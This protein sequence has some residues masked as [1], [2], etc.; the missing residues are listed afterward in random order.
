MGNISLSRW[1]RNKGREHDAGNA[2]PYSWSNTSLNLEIAVTDEAVADPQIETTHYDV[3]IAEASTGD[4]I[5]HF[6]EG[7]NNQEKARKRAKVLMKEIESEHEV[8]GI[9]KDDEIVVVRYGDE[10]SLENET[11]GTVI[12][13][14]IRVEEAVENHY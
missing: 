6:Y 8:S 13:D 7:L 3:V 2:V 11:K 1:N 14:E 4:V 9:D 5:G 10:K 12:A